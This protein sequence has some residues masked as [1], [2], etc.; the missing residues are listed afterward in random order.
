MGQAANEQGGWARP[1][2]PVKRL[3]SVPKA[4]QTHRETAERRGKAER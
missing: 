1:T 4:A 2:F 3:C